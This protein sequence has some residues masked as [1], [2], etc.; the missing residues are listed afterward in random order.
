[1]RKLRLLRFLFSNYLVY[2]DSHL[3]YILS[4]NWLDCDFLL[5][6]ALSYYLMTS[7]Y[8][9]LRTILIFVST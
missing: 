9:L 8:H 4:L 3:A 7:I 2:F 5:I 1:M 6:I